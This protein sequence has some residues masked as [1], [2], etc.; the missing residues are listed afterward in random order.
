MTLEDQ[1]KKLEADNA[2]QAAQLAELE[3]QNKAGAE[4]IEA[5]EANLASVT[6]RAEVAEGEAEAANA[7]IEESEQARN[8]LASE[9][10]NLTGELNELKQ[11]DRDIDSEVAARAAE[12]AKQSGAAPLAQ[13]PDEGNSPEASGEESL[14]ELYAKCAA[15][16]D[17]D[18]KRAFYEKNIR[19]R[20]L[21]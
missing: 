3:A 16:S 19:S 13:N 4:R 5:L 20:Q 1:I 10:D 7:L 12:I 8:A 11:K 17:P 15:I 18:E 6:A 14:D 9:V 21:R 2:A